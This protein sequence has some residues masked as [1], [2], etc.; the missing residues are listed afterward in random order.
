MKS[1]S[2]ENSHSDVKYSRGN[3]VNNILITVS[4]LTVCKSIVTIGSLGQSL[5]ELYKCLITILYT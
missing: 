3:I 5:L 2:Y 1:A 4:G